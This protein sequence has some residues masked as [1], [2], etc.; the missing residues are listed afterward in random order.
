MVFA[1]WG[2]NEKYTTLQL[3][4]YVT[5]LANRGKRVKPQFVD[6]IETYEGELVQKFD[7]PVVLNEAEFSKQHWDAVINGMQSFVTGFDDFPYKL[8]RKTGTS[9]QGVA[10]GRTVDNAVFIAFAPLDKPKLA[11]AV[12]VPE[13]GF[14]S[15]GAAPIARKLF[16]AYDQKYGLDGVP[17]GSKAGTAVTP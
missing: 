11:V 8:A 6:R 14:G 17:K 1:S 9:T 12:V 16:D 2:Q 15:W 5:T 3:A 13:G 4:Q 10:G 7:E